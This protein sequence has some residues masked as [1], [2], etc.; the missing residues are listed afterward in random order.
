MNDIHDLIWSQYLSEDLVN[1]V[2]DNWNRLVGQMEEPGSPGKRALVAGELTE[3][4]RQ[5]QAV[6]TQVP[7]ELFSQVRGQAGVEEELCP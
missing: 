2:E 4:Q 6:G 1:G 3:R 7:H 5:G